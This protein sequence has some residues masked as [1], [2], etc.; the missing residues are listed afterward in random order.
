MLSASLPIPFLIVLTALLAA[1][2]SLRRLRRLGSL[3]IGK[4]R[5]I[6]ERVVLSLVM[7]VAVVAAA[8]TTFNVIAHDRFVVHHPAPGQIYVVNG[9]KMHLWCAGEGSPTI[10]L[11]SGAG[12][13]SLVW[14][15][16]RPGLSKT[17]R[18]CSYDRAG[19]GWSE[20]QPGP[21][22]SDHIVEQLHGLLQQ[23]DITGPI[24]LMGH[25]IAG[26]HMR[27]Y[28]TRYPQNV[29][30]I[31]FVD[32]STPMQQDHFPEELRAKMPRLLWTEILVG[33]AALY[34][35][36]PR[37]AG[38]C[39]SGTGPEDWEVGDLQGENS[40]SVNVPVAVGEYMAFEQD[41]LETIHTGP[42]G[43]LPILI[44]SQDPA[45]TV[46]KNMSQNLSPQAFAEMNSTWNQMQEDLKKLSTRS[47][48]IIAK[49]SGHYIELYRSDLLLGEVPPFIEQ[50]R[51]NAP[52]PQYGTTTTE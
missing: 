23:A 14:G 33:G 19:T 7:L 6:T 11:E 8:S 1:F 37:V 25:S 32:G 5:R 2:F 10:V 44:F 13:D 18:V 41:G 17:T 21:R 40:C 24:V 46:D 49:G 45:N 36:V 52:P 35:G 4:F 9:Y 42:Y 51:G 15:K 26:M 48:R 31:V 20:P 16:V 38:Q 28:V 29:K 47:R 22:D 30:G 39:H 3:P 43:D 12:D 27:D 50:V 34:L